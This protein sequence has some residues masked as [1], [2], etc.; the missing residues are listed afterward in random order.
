M[1]GCAAP[2]PCGRLARA[3]CSNRPG[4]KKF[5]ST[6]NMR[7]HHRFFPITRRAARLPLLALLFSGVRL[8]PPVFAANAKEPAPIEHAQP[9]EPGSMGALNTRDGLTLRLT[10]DFGPVN[11]VQLETGAAPVVRYNVHIETDA[12]GPAAQQLL[13]S[14]SLKAKSTAT[15]V[16]IT[17]MLP[18]QATRSADAQFWVQFE[19]AVPRGYSVEVNTEAGDITTGDIGGTASL[20]TQGGNIKTGR[21]GSSGIRDA[22]WGRFAAKVETEGGHIRVLDVAGDLTAFT[23]GGHINVGNIAGDASLRTGGGHIR[24]GQI[25]GRAEL[26]TAGGN[27][28]VAHAGSF[29]NVRTGGGQIDFGEVRGSVHAQTGGGSICV[30]RV[31]GALQAATSGGTITAW[32]NPEPPSGGGN[33]RLAG[34]SQLAS[35]NGDIIVFLPRN[36][37]AN[38]DAVVANGGEH[39]IE[40]DPELHMTMLASAN[41]S[42]SVHGTAVLHGGGAPLKLK[43]TGGKI[44]LKFLDSDVALHQMLVSEQVDRLNRRLAENGFAPAPFSLGAEPTAPALA[45][46][47]PSPDTKTDWLENWLDRFERALR[48]GISENPDDFQRRLV[49]SPKPSYPALAQRAGLQGF[50]KL[51]VRVKKDGS[52]EVRKLLEGEPALADAAITAVKQWRAKPASINGQPVEVISTVTF[53]FQLH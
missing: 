32:I 1:Y 6:M 43:T 25:G 35:G 47:P 26:E 27:I 42:G 4:G 20:H 9:T 17:G 12:R 28:T 10:T 8:A 51:Q 19:V 29:V 52:V 34:A 44:R 30:T 49:N 24:A 33:V 37:A 48:G 13:D 50:V 15:G 36:L 5:R 38:I 7:F 14:Y 2:L 40:A 39:R 53:N 16:E 3:K 11:I 18:P 41:G 21:I 23:G 46:V 45:D 22:A 31:A